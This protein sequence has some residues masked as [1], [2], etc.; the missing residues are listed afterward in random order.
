LEPDHDAPFTRLADHVISLGAAIQPDKNGALVSAY[1]R[2]DAVID[3]LVAAGCDAVWPGWGFVAEDPD[4][5]ARL[6][7][8][9]ICFLGPSAEAM[10]AL[11]DK[12]TSKRIAEKAGVPVTAWSGGALADRCSPS[13]KSGGQRPGA[14][15]AVPLVDLSSDSIPPGINLVARRSAPQKTPAQCLGITQGEMCLFFRHRSSRPRN[16]CP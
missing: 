6:D 8:A 7:A 10:R 14:F 11:G 4:F 9:G 3:A 15:P 16:L 12:I 1:L 13:E 5:V 2:Y